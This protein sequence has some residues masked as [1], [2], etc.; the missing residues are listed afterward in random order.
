MKSKKIIPTSLI[1]SILI[2]LS[3][4]SQKVSEKKQG[5]QNNHIII[6]TIDS[7]FSKKL[8]EQ[9]EIWVY[10]PNEFN[11]FYGKKKYPVVY[12]L[13]GSSHFYSVV[14]LVQQ[15]SMVNGNMVCPEM[16]VVGIPNTDR[17][18]DLA[19]TVPDSSTTDPEILKNSCG[20]EMFTNFIEEELIPY[21][22]KNYPTLPYR[23]LIGHSRG[24]L[25]AI[26]TLIHRPY[27]F[28]NYIAI[29]PYLEWNKKWVVDESRKLIGKTD[30]SKKSLYVSLSNFMEKEMKFTDIEKDTTQATAYTRAILEFTK[31]AE[32]NPQNQLNFKWKYYPDDDHGSVP[33]VSSIDAMHFLF[34]WYKFNMWNKILDTTLVLEQVKSMVEN[35][36]KTVSSHYGFEINTSESLANILGYYFLAYRKTEIVYYFFNMNIQ[37]YPDSPN[38]YDS[39]GDYY[40][41]Q[42]DTALAIVKFKKSLSFGKRPVTF[43]K[44]KN[45]E[46]KK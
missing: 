28:N 38:A 7:I 8:N 13:D 5:S 9:R 32:A 45:L 43:E 40:L 27:L 22:D 31:L 10:V 25:F 3:C 24:G 30:F 4:Q 29:D 16:I 12:L 18:R 46:K 41:A 17:Q 34:S 6:G 14:G 20:G 11:R 36:S 26:N 19:P 44:L 42:K 33:L 15:F 35:Y 23:T 39:M 1:F 21:I 2:L 37:N